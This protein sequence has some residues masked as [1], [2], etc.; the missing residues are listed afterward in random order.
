VFMFF[1]LVLVVAERRGGR[2]IQTVPSG[3]HIIRNHTSISLIEPDGTVSFTSLPANI[4]SPKK[5]E[6][7]GWI[8]SVWTWNDYT[9]Y[10]ASWNVP[11]KPLDYNGQ[12]IFFFNSFEDD[13][14]D[15]ILQPVLQ[16]NDG[17][18]NQWYVAAWYGVGG[19]YY[20]SNP[21]PVNPGDS[22]TGIIALSADGSTW[23]ISFTVNGAASTYLTVSTSDVAAPQGNAQFA[24]EVYGISSCDQYPP[25][26]YLSVYNIVLKVGNTGPNVQWSPSVNSQI[27]LAGA[28]ASGTNAAITWSHSA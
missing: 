27:C 28:T 26:D 22:L 8:A 14:Y 7:D 20:E 2:K 10:S 9:Y 18:G 4:N 21:A 24:M 17:G 5:R 3:T 6:T 23:K 13:T 15:D 25:S 19:N 1:L 11:P 16:F 12:T